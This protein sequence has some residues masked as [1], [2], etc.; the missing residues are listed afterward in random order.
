MTDR[1]RKG[2]VWDIR[3]R[4]LDLSA[5]ELFQVAKSIGPIPERDFSELDAEDKEGCLEFINA[6]MY[7]THL[8]ESEDRGMTEL[9]VLQGTVEA[10]VQEHGEVMSSVDVCNAPTFIY[11]HLYRSHDHYRHCACRIAKNCILPR[12]S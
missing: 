7:S 12:G 11:T 2:L 9:L 8:L 5:V 6:F 1:V 10:V 3:K 4:L